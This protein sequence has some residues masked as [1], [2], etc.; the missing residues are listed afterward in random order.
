[1]VVSLTDLTSLQLRERNQSNLCEQVPV[2]VLTKSRIAINNVIILRERRKLGLSHLKL[3]R[4]IPA[5]IDGM[6]IINGLEYD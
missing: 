3:L 1:M 5:I 2:M 4:R 6:N